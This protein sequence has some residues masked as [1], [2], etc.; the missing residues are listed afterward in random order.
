MVEMCWASSFRL[1]PLNQLESQQAPGAGT[2]GTPPNGF[3]PQ[4][5]TL[6]HPVAGLCCTHVLLPVFQDVGLLGVITDPV[7]API[8][9]FWPSD[10]ALQALPPEQQD[11]LFNQE[12]KDKLMEYLKFH[13]I[14]ESKVFRVHTDG[15]HSR[16]GQCVF[17]S[18]AQRRPERPC[19]TLSSS[20]WPWLLDPRSVPGLPCFSNL[21]SF[22]CCTA[23]RL[24]SAPGHTAKWLLATAPK[25]VQAELFSPSSKISRPRAD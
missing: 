12:N 9:L 4:K 16:N 15:V 19:P 10:Q 20:N 2:K 14:R 21:P 24:S 7:H 5:D 1:S 13:V 11:F 8:T 17:T 23:H 6:P 22:L 18:S 25:F 3:G